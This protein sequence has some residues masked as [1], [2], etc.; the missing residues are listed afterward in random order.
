MVLVVSSKGCLTKNMCEGVFLLKRCVLMLELEM[1][2]TY[3][4]PPSQTTTIW[5]GFKTCC[6]VL[7]LHRL[8]HP[9]AQAIPLNLSQQQEVL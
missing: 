7:S 2:W 5:T 8:P 4:S 9:L 6:V 1:S 3:M